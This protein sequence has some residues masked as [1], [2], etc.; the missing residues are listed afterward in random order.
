MHKGSNFSTLSPILVVF[1][2]L[3]SSDSEQSSVV[4]SQQAREIGAGRRPERSD[5]EGPTAMG[6]SLAITWSETGSL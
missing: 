5:H 4:G 6:R 3:I 1:Y 2:S